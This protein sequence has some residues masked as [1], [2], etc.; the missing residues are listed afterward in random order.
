MPRK[1]IVSYSQYSIYKT[2]P[3]LWYLQ[4]VKGLSKFEPSIHLV[5]GTSIHETLQLWLKVMYT[6]SGK[7]ADQMDLVAD[8]KTRFIEEYK[9]RVQESDGKHFSTSKELQ[10][11]YE[12]GIAI[13]E[14]VRKKRNKYFTLRNVDLVGIEIPVLT[15]ANKG[16]NNVTY[17]GSIDF[18][19]YDKD[20]KRYKIYDIKT[21]TRGW[22]DYDKKDDKKVNQVL[23]YKKMFSEIN[24][25]PEENIDVTFFIVKRKIPV[26]EDFVIGRVQEFKPTHGKIKI[27]KAYEDFQS[28]LA[29]CFNADGSYK[30]KPYYKNAGD[31]CKFCPFNN[32]PDLCDKKNIDEVA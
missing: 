29:E 12:D 27:K 15:Q 25:V 13:L 1:K 4:Y 6:Q 23:L 26:M 21:S 19:L 20:L 9:K 24:N 31:A 18:I 3:Y 28:F 5:F 30:E 8:F 7:A 22:T 32:S 2:C 10:E 14:W 17:K 16:I 11:F